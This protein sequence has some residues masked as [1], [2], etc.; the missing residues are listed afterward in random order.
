[1]PHH[2]PRLAVEIRRAY[3]CERTVSETGLGMSS[4]PERESVRTPAEAIRK[5]R[6]SVRRL[7]PTLPSFEQGRALNWTDSGGCLQGVAA[8][9]R[10]EPCGFSISSQGTRIAWAVMPYHQ[11]LVPDELLLPLVPVRS[12]PVRTTPRT[13]RLETGCIN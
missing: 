5:I 6:V 11:F 12:T 10:G 1:M 9:H 2:A 4:R 8:L 13:E 3:W 7:A